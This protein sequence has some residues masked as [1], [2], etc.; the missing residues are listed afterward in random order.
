MIKHYILNINP[1]ADS[2]WDKVVLRNTIT[3]ERPDIQNAIAQA[4]GN[5][6]GSYLISVNIDVQVLE[7]APVQSSMRNTVELP[8][9]AASSSKLWAS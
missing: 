2:D 9:I 4:I 7:K 1:Q 8:K 5:D 3:G 6:E